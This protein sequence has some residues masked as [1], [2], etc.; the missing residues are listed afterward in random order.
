MA[1]FFGVY[2][3]FSGARRTGGC[4]FA[5]L[6]AIDHPSDGGGTIVS[7]WVARWRA[8]WYTGRDERA[9]RAKGENMEKQIV[10]I[11]IQTEGDLCEMSDA[12]IKDW[13]REH[14]EQ[15]FDPAYGTPSIKIDLARERRFPRELLYNILEVAVQDN[16]DIEKGFPAD[17]GERIFRVLARYDP[18]DAEIVRLRYVE[19]EP[20]NEIAEK[21]GIPRERVRQALNGE[22]RRLRYRKNEAYLRGLIEYEEWCPPEDAARPLPRSVPSPWRHWSAK[23][24]GELRNELQHT[25]VQA[26]AEKHGWSVHAIMRAI[27]KN[28]LLPQEE[29][30]S[31][32]PPEYARSYQHWTEEE[33]AQLLARYNEGAT[34]AEMAEAHLRT[35]GGI[36]AH[37]PEVTGLTKEEIRAEMRRRVASRKAAA[38]DDTDDADDDE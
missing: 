26:V 3:F 2:V 4:A 1:C 8:V 15:M 19:G 7:Q 6:R 22:L 36:R 30:P 5:S 33:D 14:I 28:E 13:Y 24:L 17:V 25:G 32:F 21:M 31:V 38:V 34:F 23:E 16:F 18:R 10:T 9:M 37:L 20:Y 29:F 12:E 35:K 27:Y 11:T